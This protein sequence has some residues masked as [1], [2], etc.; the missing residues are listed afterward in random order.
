[1]TSRFFLPA[2]AVVNALGV[3]LLVG[4][5][6]V[7]AQSPP[8][9]P[10]AP[11]S[12]APV[13]SPSPTPR[14]PAGWVR[15]WNMLPAQA[16]RLELVSVADPNKV[17]LTA[18]NMNASAGYTELT[19]GR[20]ALQV[21]RAG[22]RQ[23]ALKNLDI[24]L[25]DGTYVTVLAHEPAAPTAGSTPTPSASASAAPGAAPSPVVIELIDDTP[26]DLNK[27]DNK[28][29]IRQFVS[30]A[31]VIVSTASKQVTDVLNYG[32][33]QTLS[34]MPTGVSPLVARSSTKT[35]MGLWNSESDFSL[36]WRST[37]LLVND[38][39]GRFRPRLTSD[40]PPKPT[41]TPKPQP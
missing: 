31:R 1:M 34:G 8:A 35:G 23:T 28:L 9:L 25:R 19:P 15:F 41:P 18:N 37:L 40:G 2:R 39:Y 7:R 17:I 5:G 33:S 30:G 29:T 16:G 20:Y 4:S 38:E 22:D 24:P 21:F 3:V 14:K 11:V 32:D 36:N 12:P 13:A 27:A 6:A 26:P 10:T